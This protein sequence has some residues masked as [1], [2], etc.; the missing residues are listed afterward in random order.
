MSAASS[1]AL[2]I[3]GVTGDLAYKQI[4]TA[5]LGLVRDEG[6]NVPVIGVAHSGWT[7]E[8]LRAYAKESVEQ[9]GKIDKA[10]LDQFLG[11]L[12]YVD[13]DYADPKMFTELYRELGDAK[14]P[15]H[16]LAVPPRFF[17]VVANGIATAG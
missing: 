14:Y 16:Y 12:R 11:L 8:K 15:L 3:Y 7:T 10:L 6:L 1:D 4:F 9:H 13:G 5:V 2:V 17:E